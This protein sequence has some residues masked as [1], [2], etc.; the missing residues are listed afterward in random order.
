MRKSIEIRL[1][2]TNRTSRFKLLDD[3]RL[4]WRFE[5]LEH[6]RRRSRWRT[7]RQVIILDHER[8]ARQDAWI[9]TFFDL[10]VDL[11]SPLQGAL[12]RQA[13]QRMIFL[14]FLGFGE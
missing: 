13:E 6:F 12:R 9:L 10:L 11:V 1:T 2:N 5:V 14:G 3:G 8:Y 4:D 7:K